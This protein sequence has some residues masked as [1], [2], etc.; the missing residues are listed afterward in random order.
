[1]SRV[2]CGAMVIAVAVLLEISA[3]Q[4]Q[5]RTEVGRLLC[6]MGPSVGVI[7]GSRQRISC[8]YRPSGG[9]IG[10]GQLAGRYVGASGD[11]SLG[12]GAGANALIGGSRRSVMLQPVS[13]V[14]QVGVN[15]A[16]GVAGLTLRFIGSVPD[17]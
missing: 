5:S 1:M 4:A 11:V 8:T 17:S 14:S 9:G 3:A 12:V 15:L 6:R 7:I 16:V 10:R 13:L 2:L